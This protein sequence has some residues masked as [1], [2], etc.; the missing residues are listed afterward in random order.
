MSEPD[1]QPLAPPTHPGAIAAPV[2]PSNW[3]TVIGII[4]IVLGAGGI[5]VGLWGAAAP[6]LM[7][8]FSWAMIQGQAE[9]LQAW[10]P[11]TVS[12]SL[13]AAAVAILLLVGGLKLVKRNP[14]APRLLR[15][16]AILKLLVAV[17]MTIVGILVQNDQFEAIQGSTGAMP[18]GP[19]FFDLMAGIGVVLSVVWYGALPVFMLIWFARKKSKAEV[20]G[21]S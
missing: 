15:L 9:S 1:P 20:A 18:L 5:L 12:S 21:W 7:R 17:F 3:P 13:A 2:R 19:G 10:L 6:L 11:W 8:W 16:W 4:A 14:A